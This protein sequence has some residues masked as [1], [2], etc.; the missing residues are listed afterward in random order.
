MIPERTK[1]LLEITGSPL[2]Y[3]I[4][5]D[6]FD[7]YE[8]L[9]FLEYSACHRVNMAL[10]GICQDAIGKEAVK[11]G[12]TIIKIKNVKDKADKRL[13][14]SNRVLELDGAWGLGADGMHSDV[15]ISR[16]L[17]AGL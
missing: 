6:S 14:F 8:S 3:D 1:E 2:Q 9:N 5:W 11:D 7:D 4:A 16:A 12:L 17:E 10:R 13:A 15:D